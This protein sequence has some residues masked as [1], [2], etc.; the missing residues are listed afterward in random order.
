MS[1]LTVQQRTVFLRPPRHPAPTPTAPVP[2]RWF[3]GVCAGLAAHLGVPAW[4]IRL[5]F[6]IASITGLPILIYLLLW[7]VVPAGDPANLHDPRTRAAVQRLV[8][9]GVGVDAMYMPIL[10][11]MGATDFAR[12]ANGSHGSSVNGGYT[13]G[14]RVAGDS[15]P[16]PASLSS[17]SSSPAAM[18]SASAPSASGTD[19]YPLTASSAQ[20]GAS[21]AGTPS[22]ASAASSAHTTPPT[23]VT[24]GPSPL[25]SASPAYS[26]T[27]APGAFTDQP[28]YAASTMQPME[29]TG[30]RERLAPALTTHRGHT[31]MGAGL[32][33]GLAVIG[34]AVIGLA[35]S[36]GLIDTPPMVVLAAFFFA[37]LAI[38]WSQAQALVTPER[39]VS[40][41]LM[42]IFGLMLVLGSMVLWGARDVPLRVLGIATLTGLAFVLAVLIALAPL[43]I[44]LIRDLS[45]TRSEQARQQVRADMAAHLHDSVLQTLNLIRKDANNP[46]R[47]ASLARSQERELRAWLYSDQP[48]AVESVAQNLRMMSAEVEDRYGVPID[49]VVVGDCEPWAGMEVLM[50]ASREALS[51]AVRHGKPPV[52]LYI[53]LG[54]DLCEVFVRDRGEGFDM[55]TIPADRHGVRDSIVGRVERHGGSVDIRMKESGT[56][57]HIAMPVIPTAGSQA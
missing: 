16:H 42:T 5:P 36:S 34:V 12:Y 33:A 54:P 28:G 56:D 48:A 20:V 8:R 53:E 10:Y 17:P 23:P 3:L 57:I 52:S 2:G 38:V 22:S 32:M 26:A 13:A 19:T 45:D 51:N 30:W 37:G 24:A 15:I 18:Y 14:S 49:A 21:S 6:A 40:T 55:D 31:T 4:M 39:G 44:R 7:V 9:N 11:S 50:G 41:V 35:S 46:E 29:A 27:T 1:S 25:L 47:V 43:W